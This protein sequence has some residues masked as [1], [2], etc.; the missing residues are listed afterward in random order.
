MVKSSSSNEEYAACIGALHVLIS[1][2]CESP[3]NVMFRQIKLHN[4]KFQEDIG[5]LPGG[6]ECMVAVGF[7]LR[8][9]EE[10]EERILSMEEPNLAA[11]MDGW[12][13]WFDGLKAARDHIGSLA[14]P[15][16]R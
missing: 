10:E 14:G 3:E 4:A 6:L 1:H 2:I 11:D 13:S 5:R 15:P 12:S 9:R 16:R 8:N 7:E